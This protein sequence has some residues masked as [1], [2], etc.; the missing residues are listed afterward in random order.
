MLDQIERY[1]E[2]YKAYNLV[3]AGRTLEH[4]W[5]SEQ[6]WSYGRPPGGL[7]RIPVAIKD[8]I[9][10]T[11]PRLKLVGFC[12]GREGL[13]HGPGYSPAGRP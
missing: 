5:D 10:L 4:T 9:H 2:Q 3:D 8:L 12:R 13:G 11:L 7:D 1:N 6:R